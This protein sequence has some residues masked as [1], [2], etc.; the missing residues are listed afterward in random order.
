MDQDDSRPKHKEPQPAQVRRPPLPFP[1][2][3][4]MLPAV[5]TVEPAVQPLQPEA[6]VAREEQAPPVAALVL[7]PSLAVAR[8]TTTIGCDPAPETSG[9]VGPESI[10]IRE[11]PYAE[12]FE[13]LSIGADTVPALQPPILETLDT[14]GSDQEAD[15][16]DLAPG[17]LA[18]VV[19]G[20]APVAFSLPIALNGPP[21]TPL[22]PEQ[23]KPLI[24]M[25]VA[26]DPVALVPVAPE[27]VAPEPVA[28]EPVEPEPVEPEPVAPEPVAPEPFAP[29]PVAPEP[30]APEPVAPVPVAPEPVAPEPVALVPV[31]PV[32]VAPEPVAPEPVA[33]E[34]VEPEPVALVPVAPVPVARVPV[35]HVPVAH[36]PVAP[37]TATRTATANRTAA[38]RP[39]PRLLALIWRG[40]R[41]AFTAGKIATISVV[42][43]YLMMAGLIA[44]YR[45]TDPNG[46]ALM[47]I[48]WLGGQPIDQRWAPITAIS[49]SLRRAV[50]VSED[51][52]FCRHKGFDFGEIR[53]A[54]KRGDGFGRGASTISQQLAKNLFLW[55]D[56]SY[57]RKAL[58]VPLTITIEYLWPKSR[59]FEVYL[60][61]VEW[62]P[63]IFGAEAAAR[64]YFEKPASQLSDREAALLAVALP[65]PLARD[66]SDP[67]PLQA[68]LAMR[69]QSRMRSPMTFPCIQPDIAPGGVRGGSRAQR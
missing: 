7:L 23:A 52:Q 35:A 49:P 62:G 41:I 2:V 6:A 66:A 39:A 12:P 56:R 48:R 44:T 69:L 21:A 57:V 54:M 55:P 24:P 65:N 34:P 14:S 40:W 19:V 31:A 15:G 20:H 13:P 67:E 10:S 64:A 38:D 17:P 37:L 45:T 28:P 11:T 25:P 33:P 16:A 46:S 26:P 5:M 30:V 22:E 8:S 63:G 43:W 32:P 4:R 53:S 60:N 58:E 29:V 50:M 59:I 3:P 27:P 51:G 42:V 1:L 36:V 18:P 9:R 47:T 68:R 61:V